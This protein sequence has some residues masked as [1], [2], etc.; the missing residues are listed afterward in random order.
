VLE[1]KPGDTVI[2]APATGRYGAMTVQVALATGCRV[3]AAGR[4]EGKLASLV[5]GFPDAGRRLIT[6]RL[7]GDLETDTGALTA[8]AGRGGADAYSDWSPGASEGSTHVAACIRALRPRGRCCL[9]GGVGGVLQNS[10]MEFV[11]KGIRVEGRNM[12]TRDNALQIIKMVEA[13]VLKLG[14][15]GVK[16][17]DMKGGFKVDD[18][19]RALAAADE[20]AS[21]AH[22]VVVEP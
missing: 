12:F 15:Q 17:F 1:T 4:S 20:I 9:M 22:L 5:S 2:V 16:G 11:I 3:V 7:T 10:M 14:Q 13:G 8:A 21:W 6:V 18:V 19:H